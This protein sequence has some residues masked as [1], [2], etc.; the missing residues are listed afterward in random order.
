MEEELGLFA[1]NNLSAKP[2]DLSSK[3]TFP[4]NNVSSGKPTGDPAMDIFNTLLSEGVPKTGQG[5]FTAVPATGLDLSGRYPK[6]FPGLDNEDLYARNQG[7]MEKLGNSLVKMGGI[8]SATFLNSTAG[9]LYGTTELVKTGDFT[10]L[11]DNEVTREL[12]DFTIGLEDTYA[13]YKTERERNGD[14]W[15]PENLF[16]ANFLTENIIKNL[17]FS[18]GAF[19]GGFA[20]TGALRALGITGRLVAQGKNMAAAAD[21]AIASANALP[22]AQRLGAINSALGQL[23]AG[24][25]RALIGSEKFIVPAIGAAGEAGIEALNASQEIRQKMVDQYILE[26][27]YAPLGE[28][29]EDINRSVENIGKT[30]YGLNFG[31]LTFSNAVQLPKIFSS[32]YRGEKSLVNDVIFK[33]G[34]YVSSIPEKGIARSLYKGYKAGGLLFNRDEALEEALQYAAQV[35]TENYFSKLN[36][37]GEASILDDLFFAGA[38]EAFTSSEGLLNLVVGGLSGALMS[39][40]GKIGERGLTG[41]G[42]TSGKIRNEAIDAWNTSLI[43]DKLKDSAKVISAS[44]KIQEE[45]AQRIEQGDISGAKDL[46]FDFMFGAVLNRAKYSSTEVIK[47]ELNE[48]RQL[49][50]TNFLTLQQEGYAYNTDTP[51]TFLKRLDTIQSQADFIGKTYQDINLKF[52]GLLDK[53]NKPIYSDEV[54]SKLTYAASKVFDYDARIP[55]L[56]NKMIAAGVNTTELFSDVILNGKPAKEAVDKA[57]ADISKNI[58]NA[59]ELTQDLF[60]LIEMGVKRKKFIDE[61][62]EIKANPNKYTPE[63]EKPATVIPE[64]EVGNTVK[65]VTKDGEKS[66]T[67]GEEYYLGK[68]IG[69]DAEG[70]EIP[71]YPRL[72]ILKQNE[73]G[74]IR[75]RD[76]KGERDIDP[77][78]LKDY[79]LGKV[80]TVAKNPIAAFYV[81]NIDKVVKWNTGKDKGGVITGWLEY[82]PDKNQL[83]FVYNK[84]GKKRKAK[85]RDNVRV[86]IGLN[87]KDPLSA[88]RPRKGFDKGIFYFDGKLTA[89]SKA[90]IE[91]AKG[92]VKD[93]SKFYDLN[94]REARAKFFNDFNKEI[95]DNQADINDQIRKT[96]ADI[97]TIEEE[98]NKLNA[99]IE[100]GGEDARAKKGTKLKVSVR[101]ALGT[102]LRLSRAKEELQEELAVLEAQREE[103]EIIIAYLEDSLQGISELDADDAKGIIDQLEFEVELAKESVENTSRQIGALTNLINGI[104]KALDAAVGLLRNLIDQFEINYPKV[105]RVMGLAFNEFLKANPNFLKLK[106]NY[107]SD[108]RNLDTYI[109]EVEDMDINPNEEKL[110]KLRSE[111]ASLKTQ[112]TTDVNELMFKE[113]LLAKL[114]KTYSEYQASGIEEEKLMK[115]QELQKRI[116]GTADKDNPEPPI[117]TKE[118]EVDSKKT[119]EIIP[120]ATLPV[121][122]GMPHHKRAQ[123][124]GV[125]FP[126][127]D[128]ETRSNIKGVYITVRNQNQLIP[129]LINHLRT[130]DKG[131]KEAVDP[132][133]LIAMV[134][135]DDSSGTPVLVNE[136]GQPLTE[137]QAQD[138]LNNAIYQ[139]FPL[140]ELKW[141]GEYGDKSMFPENTPKNVI[142]EVKSQYAQW[143]SK[144]LK[145]D[146]LSEIH[147]VDVSFGFPQVQTD[148]EG[149]KLY[150]TRTGVESAELASEY[151]IENA[152]MIL[153]ASSDETIVRGISVTKSAPG[154]VFL[155][156]PNGLVP[157]NNRQHT[158]KEAEVIFNAIYH[159]SK[160]MMDSK[161]GINDDST[162]RLLSFLKSVVYWKIP[163]TDSGFS[164]VFFK[165]GKLYMSGKGAS[166]PFTPSGL[167]QNKED[168]ITVL[169]GMYHNVNNLFARELNE[170]YEQITGI[171]EDGSIQ[172]I[173]WPNYQAYLL[174]ST[175]PDGKKR[176]GQE[177]PLATNVR[178]IESPDDLNRSGIY[179]YTTDTVDDYI[180]PEGKKQ[181]KITPL[182]SEPVA[183]KFTLDGTSRNEFFLP[184]LKK[185]VAF[186]APANPTM[187]NIVILDSPDLKDV[188]S[189][190]ESQGQDPEMVIKKAILKGILGNQA[191]ASAETVSSNVEKARQNIF[192]KASTPTAPTAPEA[193][194]PGIEKARQNIFGAAPTTS[195]TPTT[196]ISTNDDDLKTPIKGLNERLDAYGNA[197]LVFSSDFFEGERPK[198]KLN[199]FK[200]LLSK[201][202]ENIIVLADVNWNDF[203]F[204]LSKEDIEKL[205]EL[206]PLAEELDTINTLKISSSDTRTVAVEKRYAQLTN[207]LTNKF[208]DIVG[209]HV[210]QQ[211][212][213]KI[214]SSKPKINS[215]STGDKPSVSQT[216]TDARKR[217]FGGASSQSVKEEARKRAEE[218]EKTIPA[219][220]RSNSP[221]FRLAVEQQAKGLRIENW[222]DI[223]AAWKQMLPNV[224]LYRLK[225]VIQAT[226][227]RQAWGMLKNGA[228]YVYENAEVGTFYH[229][230]F[231]AVWKM[232]TDPAEQQSIINEF[233]SRKG[234]FIDRPTGQTVNYSEATP[235]Q[236]KEQ[237]A[238]EFR[239]YRLYKKIPP[240]PVDGRP[241]IVKL[242]SDMVNFIKT[243]FTG[244]SAQSNTEKL[245]E[246]IGNGY[247]AKS[248]PPMG[249]LEQVSTQIIDLDEAFATEED[250]LREIT[251]PYKERHELIQHMVYK[252]L[253]LL[254]VN[255]ESLFNVTNINRNYLYYQLFEEVLGKVDNQGDLV[256]NGI[257]QNQMRANYDNY[258]D[259]KISD[260]E[261]VKLHDSLN[262]NFVKINTE[263]REIFEKYEEYMKGYQIEFDE[264]DNIQLTDEDKTREISPDATKIDSLRKSNPAIKLLLATLPKTRTVNGE[265]ETVVT[266]I[267]GYELLPL[268]QSFITV[269]NNVYSSRDVNDMMERLRKLAMEDGNYEVLYKRLSKIPRDQKL[270][271]KPFDFRNLKTPHSI[272][273]VSAFWSTFK[274]Q[275]PE[276]KN[277][278]ILENGEVVVGDASL[279]QAA[280]QV[281]NDF[282]NGII[283]SARDGKGYLEYSQKEKAYVAKDSID[284]LKFDSSKINEN[285]KA[286][287]QF[288][289]DIGV[290]FD[291]TDLKKLYG[292]DLDIFRNA[293]KNIAKSL[294]ENKILMSL[295]K[296]TISIQ[297]RLT[298]LALLKIK[299]TNPE[300]ESTFFNISNERTQ[301][302]I[303]VNPL[304]DL[305]DFI[306]SLVNGK[307]ELEGSKVLE[308][309]YRYLAYDEFSRGSVILNKLFPKRGKKI[310]A[311]NP[312]ADLLTV[313]YV[314]GTQNQI[315]GKQKPS[316]KLNYIERLVQEMNLNLSGWY[317]NLVPGDASIEWM[318]KMGNHVTSAQMERGYEKVNEI[319]KEY[320]K[321]EYNLAKSPDRYIDPEREKEK[322]NLRFFYDI[323]GKELN[324]KI[325]ASEETDAEAVYNEFKD[326]INAAVK[327]YI[328][329]DSKS[330]RAVLSKYG[331]LQYDGRKFSLKNIKTSDENTLG[332]SITESMDEKTL[333]NNLLAMTVNYMIA[334]VELHKL[335]YSDPYQYA[336]ELKRIKSFSSPRQAIMSD[337]DNGQAGYNINAAL[338]DVWN[339][340]FQKGDIG[341]TD[342]NRNYFRTATHSDVIAVVDIPGQNYENYKETDGSGIISLK[343]HRNLKLRAGQWTDNNDLQYRHDIAFEKLARAGATQEEL[344]KFDENNPDIQDTYT[345]VK[346]IVAGNLNTESGNND[347]VLDKFALYPLSYRIL[348]KIKKDSNAMKLYDKMQKEDI[349]YI[350]FSSGRKVGGRNPHTTY[351]ADGSFNNTPYIAS[352]KDQNILNVPY[353]IVSIQAEVPSKEK[354]EVTRGSQVTKLLTMDFMAAGVPVDFMPTEKDFSKRY[355]AWQDANDDQRNQSKLYQEIKKNEELLKEMT[356]FGFESLLK[357][358][359]IK[360]VPGGFKVD[361]FSAAT[362]TLREEMLKREVNDNLIES[363]K[364]FEKGK[365]I[366]EATPAYQKVRNILYSIVDREIV[367]PKISGGMKVQIPSTFLL[368]SNN[369]KVE[370]I[371]NKT[372]FVS[373]NLKFYLNEKGERVA[374][375]MVGKWFKSDMSDEELLNYLNNTDGG[376]K[377][378]TGM[379]FRIPTQN[380][381]SIDAIRIAKFLPKE[382]GDSVVIPS[383]LVAKV[384]SDF[385]IDKLSIYLKNVHKD[386]TGDIKLVPFQGYGQQAIDKFKTLAKELSDAE[387]ARKIGKLEKKTLKQENLRQ[388]FV[389]IVTENTSNK[390]AQHWVP[391]FREWFADQIVDGKLSVDL[392]SQVF[393]QRFAKLN[394]KLSEL[395]D[396]DLQEILVEEHADRLYKSSLQNAYIE[397]SENLIKSDENYSKLMTPNSAEQLKAL[398]KEVALA[399]VGQTYD[400]KKVGNMLNRTFMSSLRHAFV[401]GKYAIG[402]AAVNQT[403]HSL[404]QRFMS[405][406]DPTR[407]DRVSKEDRHWLGDAK[408]KFD[409]FNKFDGKAT[410]SMIRNAERTEEYPNGQFISDII[411]QFIDGYVDISK[412]PWIMELGATP[413]VASTW[414]FLVKIGVPINT[415]TYFMNQPIVRDYLQSIENAGYSWLFID[416]FVDMTKGK[417]SQGANKTSR[418]VIPNTASLKEMMSKSADKLSPNEKADQ[419]FILDEF[420]KY[421]KMAEHMFHVTQGSNYDTSN[422]NDPSLLYKKN[423]QFKKAQQT[424]ISSVEEILDNSFIGELAEIMGFTRNALSEFLVS[425]KSRVRNIIEKV[426]KPHVELS[427]ND[428]VR[429]AQ[430]VVS[431]L[432]DYAVQT[433]SEFKNRVFE[434]MVKE[435]G[436]TYEIVQMVKDIKNDPEHPLYNNHVINIIVPQL[437]PEAAPGAANNIK[438]K[439]ASSKIYDQNNIIYG[440]EEIKEY[441]G[442]IGQAFMYN[443]FKML[444]LYQSGLSTS[445]LSFTSLLPFEDFQ[446]IY[447]STIEKLE[448]IA[449]L[450]EFAN[451]TVFE[452]NN[453]G[454]DDIVPYEKAKLIVQ[455]DGTQKYNPAMEYLPKNVKDAIESNDIVPLISVST[456]GRKSKSD[457]F[458]YTW[459]DNISKEKK[460]EMRK[461]GDFSYIKRGLFKKVK[462]PAT[463]EPFIHPNN[464]GKEYYIFKATNAWGARERA[465]EFYNVEKP[466]K[467]DNGFIKVTTPS[468]D[469]SIIGIFTGRR[470]ASVQS[471][472]VEKAAVI[473]KS[474]GVMVIDKNKKINIYAGTGENSEL[475]NFVIR[476]FTINGDEYQSVEQYFQYQKWNYLKEDIT[477]A[478]FKEDQKIADAIMNTSNGAT[479][480]SLGQKFKNLDRKA[481]DMNSSKEMKIALLASFVQNPNALRR[482]LSTGN[483][484]LTHTQD[485]GKW[486]TEFPKLLMEVRFELANAKTL[487]S[488][489]FSPE[490]IGEIL[491]S[492]C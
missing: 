220:K 83:F 22:Q 441:L 326:K 378:L 146:D 93:L 428:F 279:S 34:K 382:F 256:K 176:S 435:G 136:D 218:I 487:E 202:R 186:S 439:G 331:I 307:D 170:E 150:D 322:N 272:Q 3:L 323:L 211:L 109:A 53:D 415:I 156:L 230:V 481:W 40:P 343:G 49:A 110:Q 90:K 295:S 72:T 232:F 102:S 224:P 379:A 293:V 4:N 298:E 127:F 197:Q 1:P 352:G 108:L 213:K 264:N 374:E 117:P 474:K 39:L 278:F 157:L 376:K 91:E 269:M 142:D 348:H 314:G 489:G 62:A 472:S 158:R 84:K 399:T 132:T 318:I 119:V 408:I 129:G 130:D 460:A 445:R 301:S 14:W 414:L 238:E 20:F 397:S 285:D 206:K 188:I 163:K 361:D 385:D 404:M 485:K 389:D 276:V 96:K 193:T 448:S 183:N 305:H 277:V 131:I 133:R 366:L 254:G 420:L 149:K 253:S 43:K 212:G 180:I 38:K 400:Y 350:V 10:K 304:S 137:A 482:I 418:T 99:I 265:N 241:W 154:R 480:K 369:I 200:A 270:K 362:T 327:N 375:I 368:D 107:I 87:S 125:K 266:S 286:M 25:G 147:S 364:A 143:R 21:A 308:S 114:K 464:S 347:V 138:P 479:L 177:L 252:T 409:Q 432:F 12:N 421:A 351:N 78:V 470:K 248:I 456:L 275:N 383:A 172:S 190:V 203:N 267:G 235:Q 67:I 175:T 255:D 214:T 85:Q 360:R 249:V 148:S 436:Y 407:L 140:E 467:I 306:S 86:P 338:N 24:T 76:N 430:K 299:A 104:E 280:A 18:I 433:N 391:L 486:G 164:S 423:E 261:F 340:G 483:A 152:P 227:G 332:Y 455:Q 194:S 263:W 228:I 287:L 458:V 359:G 330:F 394:K 250:E 401:T 342:F 334:N 155:D 437:S 94:D 151:D 33:G 243:F 244:E 80:S 171:S 65:V 66:L 406:V 59:D 11:F 41:E 174:S 316:A 412:G 29:L 398:G 159:F 124:F 50:S 312:N 365:V 317:L 387:I 300:I 297:G 26:K 144:V 98:L 373:E 69:Y 367:S 313:G 355:K 167:L 71:R 476:P 139:V 245:F 42:G 471:Q 341:Y 296:K 417:Y 201:L 452:R 16:T 17:G 116:L 411:G 233:K 492:I 405:L 23:R 173:I 187:D 120:R 222:S 209:K 13:N 182:A 210:E 247:Y 356:K 463:G 97:L 440:F 92:Q 291:S 335:L 459:E 166:Y 290:D 413:N 57:M 354:A 260:D 246:K 403:N 358:F 294:R 236:I 112:L 8:A 122:R 477:E 101:K 105:P 56:N 344:D 51:E 443:K 416:D 52:K 198:G 325:I 357:K 27:G 45:R 311:N 402:I 434:V 262:E 31:L 395:T 189:Y 219:S 309:H 468:S 384:G 333:N 450:E 191:Q 242:F 32:T 329:N 349:D 302:Y 19:A 490:E 386:V 488:L 153:V 475:S 462:D 410:L 216:V 70:N 424:I 396:A 258:R 145:V 234:S 336:D 95:I 88:F 162:K 35:G 37:T 268:A 289:K 454:N 449:N 106:P 184:S 128:D 118:Y 15:E 46:E 165:D 461:K 44:A 451:L 64:E 438:V 179:F 217:I 484:E 491:N 181:V 68:V 324:D 195:S 135:V 126:K 196:S 257:L 469:E 239:D 388:M 161:K 229:E 303:G 240:K 47:D 372:G 89:V 237:L 447:E 431:D 271:D 111:I 425:E 28:D 288:L 225:N 337:P 381:N 74:T 160:N 466:S 283:M 390:F 103:G 453:W 73:D 204:F 281:A 123:R 377:I 6:V 465:Q 282:E 58:V 79:K 36:E 168:I 55:S 121:D 60:E 419:L 223:E 208:I 251:L 426:L 346:P 321:A 192:G 115:N 370:T 100:K 319:F 429:V 231:E 328:E 292:K 113:A 446:F 315:N 82:D 54:I 75:I 134:M 363:L 457:F 61:Y 226:N 478:Q 48:L 185:T 30:I 169:S 339:T 141:S 221:E 393:E 284:K 81:E 259:G 215:V 371:N 63:P 427:N 353:K 310:P 320:F 392:V 199:G 205:N 422:F 380:S 273:L 207:Q 9:F 345:P 77:E 178:P 473:E 2:F 274:K 5:S 442:G 444:A 7:T